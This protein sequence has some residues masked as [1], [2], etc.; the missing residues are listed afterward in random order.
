LHDNATGSAHRN[1]AHSRAKQSW[2]QHLCFTQQAQPQPAADQQQQPGQE[3]PQPQQQE[4]KLT[5]LALTTYQLMQGDLG[6]TSWMACAAVNRDAAYVHGAPTHLPEL[7]LDA[8]VTLPLSPADLRK[9]ALSHPAN[10]CL[11]GDPHNPEVG[12]V[13]QIATGSPSPGA[14][15]G[16]TAMLW[17]PAASCMYDLLQHGP[18][19]ASNCMKSQDTSGEFYG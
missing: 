15:Q 12:A 19:P 11:W 6:L 5:G 7:L 16:A 13:V 9:L 17:V 10:M 14:A 4:V 3:A 1:K 2:F 18:L 8:K